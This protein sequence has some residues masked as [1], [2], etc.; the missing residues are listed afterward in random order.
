MKITINGYTLLYEVTK[1]NGITRYEVTLISP[2]GGCV[3]KMITSDRW[4]GHV[5]YYDLKEVMT[6]SGRTVAA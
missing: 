6:E 1:A 2:T 3:S 4:K 5:R